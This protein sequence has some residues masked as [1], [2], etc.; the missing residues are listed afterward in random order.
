LI[1]KGAA[2]S[3]GA[4]RL[5]EWLQETARAYVGAPD[6]LLMPKTGA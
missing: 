5:A 1:P 3:Q 4:Q 2:L 6:T